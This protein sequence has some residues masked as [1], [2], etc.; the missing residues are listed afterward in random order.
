M[1]GIFFL[2]VFS[3][4]GEALRAMKKWPTGIRR[5][6]AVC[7]ACLA[8]LGMIRLFGG[9]SVAVEQDKDTTGFD[10]LLVPYVAFALTLLI[11]VLRF[12]VR[13]VR[14]VRRGLHGDDSKHGFLKRFSNR[15][16]TGSFPSTDLR[17]SRVVRPTGLNRFAPEKGIIERWSR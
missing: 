11:V 10:F 6:L 13:I 9:E 16:T 8:V 2:V 12:L 7:T 3:V 1:L 5:T 14:A 17:T 4:G 15:S